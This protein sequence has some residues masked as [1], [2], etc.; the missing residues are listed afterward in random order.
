MNF[1]FNPA[2]PNRAFSEATGLSMMRFMDF[3]TRAT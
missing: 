2:S 3:T 1:Q